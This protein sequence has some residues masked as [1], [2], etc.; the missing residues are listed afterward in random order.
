MPEIPFRDYVDFRLDALCRDIKKLDG[1]VES[2][3]MTR[4]ELAG[5]AN[6]SSVI[7]AYV[8]GASGLVLSLIQMLGGK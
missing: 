1:D 7:I 2:L 4:A 6:Q 8:L 5:K 3:K